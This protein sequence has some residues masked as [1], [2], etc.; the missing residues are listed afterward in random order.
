VAY[1]YP[2]LDDADALKIR[3]FAGFQLD[4]PYNYM[5]VAQQGVN[6]LCILTGQIGCAVGTRL[7]N[8]KHDTFFCSELIWVA[9]AQ[10]GIKLSKTAPNWS[11]PGDVPTLQLKRALDYVGHLKA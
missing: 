9:Y 7:I 5:G 1:R 11:K 6:K 4:K 8:F 2:E 3:D 10:V